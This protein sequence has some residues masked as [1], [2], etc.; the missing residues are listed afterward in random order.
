MLLFF[1]IIEGDR[2]GA[3]FQ[4]KP[5]LSIGRRQADIVL[6]DSKVS[7][8]H[9]RI[10]L[11]DDNALYLVDLGSA[12]GIK[13]EGKRVPEVLLA[14]GVKVQLGRTFIQVI[15]LEVETVNVDA[16]VI[17]TWPEAL[18]RIASDA[19]DRGR[20]EKRE[21]S[22]FNPLVT[23]K[24]LQGPQAGT[25]WLLGY[26]PRQIGPDSL[27][28]TIEGTNNPDAC[29]ELLPRRSGPIF[30][31]DHPLMVRLNGQELRE[32]ELANGDV[33]EIQQTR[34]QIVF[35]DE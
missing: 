20:P 2:Q 11:R 31:T 35:G 29:F 1:E 7:S 24:F 32:E 5:D 3:R 13:I 27:D 21:V 28:L 34:I 8:R 15:D 4:I 18:A 9:A 23:L 10:E 26:G 30:R 16:P 12:N 22:A 25:E 33:I 17:E 14:P 6:R 19:K